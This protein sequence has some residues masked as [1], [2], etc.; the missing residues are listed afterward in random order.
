MMNCLS[1]KPLRCISVP[2]A[3]CSTQLTLV[4]GSTAIFAM[5]NFFEALPTLGIEKSMEIETAQGLNLAK[6]AAK[7]PTLKHY[8]WSTLP[9]SMKR[10]AGKY[11]VPNMETKGAV[12]D[13][14]KSNKYL[15]AK[16]TFIW[17]T[18][19]ASNFIYPMLAPTFYVSLPLSIR[20]GR[21][22]ANMSKKTAGKYVQMLPCAP[23]TPIP[24]IGDVSKNL[25]VFTSAILSQPQLT[26]SRYVLG[27]VEDTT[28]A[29]LLQIWSEATGCPSQFV[30]MTS[31]EEYNSLFPLW[32]QVEGM[33]LQFFEEFPDTVWSGEDILTKEDLGLKDAEFVGTKATFESM[34][35]KFL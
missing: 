13:W 3:N 28:A 27:K 21:K 19:Y 2:S 9:P 22:S 17:I 4:Q 29:G 18:S 25:G 31:L 8:L 30:Q 24:M 16:T 12:D 34:D 26:A 6:A 32:G 15:Y 7:T 10:S 14:I 35:W 33:I 11:L 1:S 20:F 5:T 23:S